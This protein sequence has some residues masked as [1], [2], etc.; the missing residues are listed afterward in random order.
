MNTYSHFLLAAV[1]RKPLKKLT[2]ENKT[3]PP[4]RTSALLIGSIIPDSLLTIIAIFCGIIDV[5]RGTFGP[6]NDDSLMGKLFGDWF[7]NNPWVMS[8]QQLF[9]SP[10][11]VAVFIAIGYFL[12]KRGTRGGG[13]FFWLSCSAMLHTLVDIPLHYDDGPLLLWP[14]NWDL[15]YFSPVSYWDPNHFGMPTA[16]YEH[17]IDIV[18]IGILIARR[19]GTIWTQNWKW[20]AIFVIPAILLIILQIAGVFNR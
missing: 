13:W 2:E 18:F 9:H 10:L 16:I 5:A 11:M 17:F 20:V 3:L 14:L 6:S 7:F 12:W 4:L 15:R 1:L 8:A 19:R